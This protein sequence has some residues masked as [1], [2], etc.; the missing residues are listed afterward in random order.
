[1]FT[2][3]STNNIPII[4]YRPA[5][6]TGVLIGLVV[7]ILVLVFAGLAAWQFLTIKCTGTPLGPAMR[8]PEHIVQIIST[9]ERYLPSLHRNHAKDRFR[10]DLLIVPIAD[11]TRQQTVTLIRQQS[12]NALLPMTK[13]LGADGDV[14]WVQALD[15]FA[16]NLK[17]RRVL[18]LRDVQK[19]N[20]ELEQFLATASFDFEDQLIAISPDQRQ[21]YAVSAETLKV[22]STTAPRRTAE[23]WWSRNAGAEV[24]LC[25]GGTI[26]TNEWLGALAAKELTGS[27]KPGLSLPRDF[28]VN[29]A[30][31]IRQLHRARIA[32][33]DVRPRVETIERLSETEYR[34]GAFIRSD[35]NSTILRLPQ[36]DSVLLTWRTSFLKDGTTLVARIEPTGQIL[37]TT[38]SGI[39][40]L[41]QILPGVEMTAF[42]GERPS[43]PNKVPEPIL[44]LVNTL[45]GATNIVSLW[46]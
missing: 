46:R 18:R 30:N 20:P 21:A 27:F 45:T 23:D 19:A 42:I 44:V 36:P 22:T 5:L 32:T 38:D 37:W 13:I 24:M 28:S 11:P 14:V 25:S 15:L 43:V 41:K 17:T 34:N 40:Y 31:E 35:R 4:M 6:P 3:K 8:A 26:T 12:H 29:T 33:N 10:L 2:H 9:Q 1:M 39:D 16:V 7:T